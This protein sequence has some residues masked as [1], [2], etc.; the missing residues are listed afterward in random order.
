[1]YTIVMVERYVVVHV[2]VNMGNDV[3]TCLLWLDVTWL[4]MFM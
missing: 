4:Y 1:M 3:C 2:H